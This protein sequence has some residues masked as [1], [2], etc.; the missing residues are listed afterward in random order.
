MTEAAARWAAIGP[1]DQLKQLGGLA[2]LQ[3]VVSGEFPT[4]PIAALLGFRFAEVETGR[5]V[6]SLT[7]HAGHYN[8]IQTV[9][10]GVHATMLDTVMACCILSTLP[11]GQGFTTLEL[12]I[13]Y[14]R[15]MT[16]TTGTVRAEGKVIN[17]GRT[18]A[19]SEGRLTDGA[20]KLIAHGTTTCLILPL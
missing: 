6:V 4:P 5:A 7:P 3:K 17:A 14:V 18:I 1:L 15:P 19:T 16:D 9:H 10:G 13:N 12:K 20:G 8:L 2:F 11:L